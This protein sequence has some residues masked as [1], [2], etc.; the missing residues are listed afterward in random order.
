MSDNPYDTLPYTN[1]VYSFS[2]PDHLYTIARLFG[3]DAPD[4]RTARVL[5]LGCGSGGNA[6]SIADRFPDSRVIAIDLSK[7]QIER[8]ESMR[9]SAGLG[10]ITFR[11][12]S[13]LDLPEM[14]CDE[15]GEFDYLICHG[16]YSYVSQALREHIHVLCARHLAANGVAYV[17]Y[18]TLPG[19]N[20]VRTLRDMVLYHTSQIEDQQQKAE[21]SVRLLNFVRSN[22]PDEDNAFARFIE[23]ECSALEGKP[24][25]YFAHEYLESVN[26]PC[27]F[28]EFMAAARAAGLEYLGDADLSTMYAGNLGEKVSDTLSNTG[29]IVRTEQ[30]MD[31]LNN[32]R[33]RKTLLCRA[34]TRVNRTLNAKSIQPFYVTSNVHLSV[35]RDVVN[36]RKD[37]DLTFQGVGDFKVTTKNRFDGAFLA[38]ISQRDGH[39]IGR[40][41]WLAEVKS[42]TGVENV[43]SFADLVDATV[44]ALSLSGGVNLSQPPEN[45]VLQP[46]AMPVV[47]PLARA[48]SL[49]QSWGVNRRG[50]T[51]H[52]D[53]PMRLIMQYLDG[54]ND[55]AALIG[56]ICRHID[57]GEL[58]LQHDGK[59]FS[60]ASQRDTLLEQL[61]EDLLQK[62]GHTA[63]LVR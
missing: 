41:E 48:Q 38:G 13:L 24:L 21:E 31:F 49:R 61:I 44:L 35:S 19:W 20:I 26:A 8:A 54:T 4:Y 28:H 55:H 18:N 56:H 34:E 50:Q 62:L 3:V 36:F 57:S 32:R 22:Q 33:F 30:Y 23:Q 1:Q 27:Y 53:I 59:A 63:L 51:V 17:S 10:N 58:S 47:S 15:F 42:L 11:Q 7:V 46:S 29:D 9:Q 5:E 60:D 37:Q 52:F 40:D 39:P 25:T 14:I 16:V 2:H 43:G 12:A 6:L 45:Y